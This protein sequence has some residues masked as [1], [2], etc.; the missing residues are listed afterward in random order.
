MLR[1]FPAIRFDLMVGVG[2]GI[3][4]LNK[5]VDIR[6]GDVVVS[7]PDSAHGGV[8]QYDLRKNLGN[9]VFER[10]GVL[11]PPPT[12]LLTALTNLQ[13]RQQVYG[14]QISDRPEAMFRNFADA[15]ER[16]PLHAVFRGCWLSDLTFNREGASLA[17]W[18][19]LLPNLTLL[20]L[21]CV[22]CLCELVRHDSLVTLV[23]SEAVLTKDRKPPET[24]SNL[25]Q[26]S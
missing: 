4:N 16:L 14:N 25:S 8:V 2:G 7:Q 22:S 6:L 15:L 11:R 9:G 21:Q 3:P 17:L 20:S 26:L 24:S 12:L 18:L 13:S 10:K 23:R 5:G 19:P 1:T